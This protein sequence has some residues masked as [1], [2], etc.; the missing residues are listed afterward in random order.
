MH[1]G[2]CKP[3]PSKYGLEA[4]GK[5]ISCS[6]EVEAVARQYFFIRIWAAP[7][8]LSLFAFKG[9]FI[10]MQNTVFSMAVD[11]WVNVVNMAASWLLAFHTTLGMAGIAWG[12]LIAQWTGLLLAC[13]LFMVRY[14]GLLSD[15]SLHRSVKWRYIKGFFKVNTD[16]FIRSLAFMVIY[17]GFTSLAAAYGDVEL[18]VS[19]VMM[20]LFMLFSY[21]IDGFAYAGEAL[22][23]RFIGEKDRTSLRTTVKVLFI[24]GL[25][26]SAVFTLVYIIFPI[27]VIRLL[28]DDAQVLSGCGPYLFWLVLMPVASCVAFVWDGIYIGATASAAMRDCMLFSAALFLLS[29]FLLRRLM[30]VQALYVGYF[31]H[32]VSRSIYLTV[33]YRGTILPKVAA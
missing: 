31:V 21:F 8:T 32:L 1:S 6:P 25:I 4:D 10:G 13:A 33:K 18:A 30:G 19:S 2:L 26:I 3:R 15:F 24:W 20:K 17:V 16:L 9:W 12:T 14:R 5:I 23:G 22:S 29:Y 27:P 11:L 28:T 7:A